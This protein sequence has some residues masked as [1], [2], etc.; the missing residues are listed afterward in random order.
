MD[1]L[2]QDDWLK[3]GASVAACEVAG[4]AGAAFMGPGVTGLAI[5]VGLDFVTPDLAFG[6][7]LTALYI[8]M[9][10]ALFLV[11][12]RARR[13]GSGRALELFGLQLAL[14][15]IWSAVFFGLKSPVGG[16]VVI[17]SLLATTLLTIAEFWR[18]DARAGAL[19]LPY[20]AWV[21]FA[22]VTNYFA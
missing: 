5:G 22:A 7:L 8:L 13:P 2:P 18:L 1:L 19:L 20:L 15:V 21:T 6:P 10:V 14:G 16:L 12:K 11:W 4:I 17:I 3:L 9:G